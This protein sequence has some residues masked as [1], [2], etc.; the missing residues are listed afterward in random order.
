ME[1]IL[2]ITDVYYTYEGRREFALRGVDLGV[3]PGES[4][5]LTGPSGCGKSTLLLLSAGILKLDKGS[6]LVGGR[7]LRKKNANFRADIRRT[8]IGLI[9]QFGELVSELSLRDNV[10]LAAE[11]AGVRRGRALSEADALLAE[12]GLADIRNEKPGEVSGG[13]A[14]RCAVARALINRPALV[15]ADEPTGSLDSENS[16][17]VLGILIELCRMHHTALVVATHDKAVAASCEKQLSMKD[18]QFV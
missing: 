16:K 9:F 8:D 10:S 5:A 17:I 4:I 13:Q 2:E 12:V 3:L 1:Q 14:Q 18:G 6:I 11:L 7:Q 15:L